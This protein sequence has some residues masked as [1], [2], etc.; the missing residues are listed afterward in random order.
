MRMKAREQ[1][2]QR[3]SFFLAG[4]TLQTSQAAPSSAS[5]MESH[6]FCPAAL[7]NKE[8]RIILLED[9]GALSQTGCR[10]F[11]RRWNPTC[12]R[13]AIARL[14]HLEPGTSKASSE[15]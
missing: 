2:G 9:Q 6:S 13:Y 4:A 11:R 5:V 14:S 15:L 12:E 3:R 10:R 8:L 7:A 1:A